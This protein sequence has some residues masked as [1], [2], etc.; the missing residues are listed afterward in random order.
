MTTWRVG[1]LGLGNTVMD[2][3][4]YGS[5]RWA[6]IQYG[7]GGYETIILSTYDIP[8]G[9]RFHHWVIEFSRGD[10][11]P[12]FVSP[13]YSETY[14]ISNPK[15][16][17]ISGRL[18]ATL[19]ITRGSGPT[20]GDTY[21]EVTTYPSPAAGGTTS[22]DGEYWG[23]AGSQVTVPLRATPAAHW[24]FDYWSGSSGWS[25]ESQNVNLKV[26]LREGGDSRSYTAHFRK[27]YYTIIGVA[28]PENGGT[29]SPARKEVDFDQTATLTATPKP[30][31]TFDHWSNGATT[32]T[33]SFTPTSNVTLTA[34]FTWNGTYTVTTRPND[35]EMGST[36]PSSQTI[37]PG[38]SV[39]ITATPNEHYR[40]VNWSDGDTNADRT[41][42]PEGPLDLVANFESLVYKVTASVNDNRA[43][44]SP[45]VQYVPKGDQCETISVGRVPEWHPYGWYVDGVLDEWHLYEYSY[46]FVPSKDTAVSVKCWPCGGIETICPA[47]LNPDTFA[48]TICGVDN[49]GPH[50]GVGLSVINFPGVSWLLRMRYHRVF[51]DIV[52]K[53]NWLRIKRFREMLVKKYSAEWSEWM[54]WNG[55][56][57]TPSLPEV[58]SDSVPK[59]IYKIEFDVE[60]L[61]GS[62]FILYGADGNIL[63]GTND[64]IVYADQM[65]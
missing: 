3:T 4:A 47:I 60:I 41:I 7:D 43:P 50:L 2:G 20:P 51:F 19:Y 52:P 49:H 44:I 59:M 6:S 27:K 15:D 39:H 13:C 34:Y 45:V 40:F 36:S 62:G 35:P 25:S 26:T 22:G 17:S 65:T 64:R 18:K 33:I 16:A 54:D 55:P 29:V 61:P 53:V 37:N 46:S 12:S 10:K 5:S 24:V 30:D 21:L 31:Y 11:A 14:T 58:G 32:P 48:I 9:Y 38:E 28:S 1:E 23:S 63:H 8:S 42:T 56:Y 57:T